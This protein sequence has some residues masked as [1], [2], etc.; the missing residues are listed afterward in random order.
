MERGREGGMKSVGNGGDLFRRKKERASPP[1]REEILQGS[2]L[3][4]VWPL[5]RQNCGKRETNHGRA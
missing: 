4:Q 3:V 2:S 5:I 1:S